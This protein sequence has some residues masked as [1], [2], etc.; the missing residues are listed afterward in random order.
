MHNPDWY[1]EASSSPDNAEARRAEVQYVLGQPTQVVP[2]VVQGREVFR[3]V[4]A[5]G[6]LSYEQ[7]KAQ[8]QAGGLGRGWRYEL[9]N[10][11]A[12][13]PQPI[14][15]RSASKISAAPQVK[16]AEPTRPRVRGGRDNARVHGRAR[17]S[18]RG[19]R[20]RDP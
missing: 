12:A 6:Q 13:V 18:G 7:L 20:H 5:A 3:V 19:R 2:A 16:P 15:E 10:L 14:A 9:P 17:V 8:A 1:W 4:V 11:S